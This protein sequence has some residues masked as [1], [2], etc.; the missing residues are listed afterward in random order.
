[1]DTNNE[2]RPELHFD[3]NGNGVPDYREPWFWG[4]L[5]TVVSWT[6]RTF[7]K[8]HTLAYRAVLEAERYRA[9]VLASQHAAGG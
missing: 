8:P 9:A 6:V 1:M 5:W 7:A 4:G 2:K 3:F